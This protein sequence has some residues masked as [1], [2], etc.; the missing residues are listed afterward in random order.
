MSELQPLSTKKIQPKLQHFKPR[1]PQSGLT[2]E[3]NAPEPPKASAS[4]Y[5]V[6]HR[7]FY[8]RTTI[9]A[10]GNVSFGLRHIRKPRIED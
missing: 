8:A 6:R 2:T 7:M 9:N 10:K 1:P 3:T 5:F 4:I